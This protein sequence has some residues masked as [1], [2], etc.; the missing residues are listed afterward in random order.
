MSVFSTLKIEEKRRRASILHFFTSNGW[1]QTGG[2]IAYGKSHSRSIII[3]AN[4][5]QSI[6]ILWTLR[7]TLTITEFQINHSHPLLWLPSVHSAWRVWKS[8]IP[9]LKNAIWCGTP[10]CLQSAIHPVEQISRTVY[11]HDTLRNQGRNFGLD[12]L[13]HF[14]SDWPFGI[15]TSG[16]CKAPP[17]NSGLLWSQNHLNLKRF[18][19]C[20]ELFGYEN[21]VILTR[22]MSAHLLTLNS[23]IRARVNVL[24]QSETHRSD[25]S[26]AAKWMI[27]GDLQTNCNIL[28]H[29][30]KL[31]SMGLITTIYQNMPKTWIEVRF[32]ALSCEPQS[33][34]S[35][36][37][38]L[39]PRPSSR[40]HIR[41]ST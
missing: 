21:D 27:M 12:V 25:T 10:P 30:R 17:K 15:Q 22:P 2:S 7:V 26:W 24:P 5:G 34:A 1:Q 19:V 9:V 18:W 20:H 35:T 33:W 16:L 41:P 37:S 38:N 6:G 31:F 14:G 28:Y 39:Q 11:G 4:R 40:L 8:V 36:P 32:E 29:F 3:P 23:A 13:L